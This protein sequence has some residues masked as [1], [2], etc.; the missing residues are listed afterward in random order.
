MAKSDIFSDLARTI[1][2]LEGARPYSAS[3][4][5]RVWKSAIQNLRGIEAV[6]LAM[7]AFKPGVLIT[8]EAA[9]VEELQVRHADPIQA[10]TD[11]VDRYCSKRERLR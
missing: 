3:P 2:E 1:A 6:L 11:L 9:A 8:L 10:V 7:D 4:Q 5:A